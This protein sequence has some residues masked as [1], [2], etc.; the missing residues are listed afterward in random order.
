MTSGSLSAS[1]SAATVAGTNTST[2]A[3]THTSTRAWPATSGQRAAAIVAA[4]ARIA[5][6]AL[7]INE[8][9]LKWHAGFGRADILLVVQ[10]TAHNP[11]VP[12]FY[13]FFTANALGGAPSL[14]GFAVPL[15][16]FGIGVA[17]VLGVVTLP[18]A[19]GSVA[20]LCNYWLADQLIVQ[21]PI[22]MA[23]S[24]AVATF[25]PSASRYSITALL[26]ARRS[27]PLPAAVR[28]WL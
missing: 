23:L 22:M 15:I 19:L 27:T 12:A 18:A 11:R 16:E 3:A 2:A 17:L 9:V 7:W 10:S 26:D 21:Y 25:A 4:L 8:A 28:R 1:M 24:V 5:L 13:K 6:G 20:E 14:F